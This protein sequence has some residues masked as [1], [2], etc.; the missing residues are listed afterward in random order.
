QVVP[1]AALARAIA[2]DTIEAA[3]ACE[4]VA[5]VLVVTADP[6][7]AAELDGIPRVALV[8][9]TV[10]SLPEAIALGLEAAGSGPRAVLLGDLPGLD[11]AELAHALALAGRAGRSYVPDADGTGTVLAAAR[12]GLGL[13]TRF[14]PESAAAHRAAGFVEL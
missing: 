4:A 1:R 14:G 2:L 9:D 6:E 12:A 5:G 13:D 3:A 11:P 8:A 7:L 10:H